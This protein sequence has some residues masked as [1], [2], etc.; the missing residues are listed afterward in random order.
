MQATGTQLNYYFVCHRKLWLF[1]NGIQME[2][3]SELVEM[4]KLIHE[5]SYADRPERFQELEIGPVKIDFY[6]KRNKVIHEIK[7][8]DKLEESH[9]W[10]V[11]YYIWLM[12]QAGI[13]GVTG[14]L[15]YPKL[16]QTQEVL[17]LDCDREELKLIVTEIEKISSSESCP[18]LVKLGICKNCSY[19]D[20]CYSGEE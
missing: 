17:L 20:F 8:T 4:G 16:R 6:D 1:S 14:V 18:P 9:R 10:Q 11:K 13:E 2:H 19:F 12:E 3:N 7:K 15:E 5:T